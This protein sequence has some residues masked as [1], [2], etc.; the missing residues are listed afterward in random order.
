V[1]GLH[2]HNTHNVITHDMIIPTH[3][4]TWL[5]SWSITMP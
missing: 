2:T 1:D 5:H 4:G 3:A